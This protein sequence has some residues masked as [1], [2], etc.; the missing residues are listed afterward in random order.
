MLTVALIVIVATLLGAAGSRSPMLQVTV[1][2]PLQVPL[3]DVADTSVSPFAKGSV[4]LTPEA[5][6]GPLL[7]TTIEYWIGIP[8]AVEFVLA[9]LTIERSACGVSESVSL[10]ELLFGLVSIAPAG[11]ET[12][13]VLVTVPVA[14]GAGVTVS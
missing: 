6:D 13:T 14:V 10:A 2:V 4:T 8:G 9:V 7:V 12:V 5:A 1:C 3:V 11:G